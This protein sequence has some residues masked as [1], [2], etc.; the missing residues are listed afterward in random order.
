MWVGGG[1]WSSSKKR[2]T[3]HNYIL[4]PG[5]LSDVEITEGSEIAVKIGGNILQVNNKIIK[6]FTK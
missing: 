1:E 5:S 2:E 6:I 4:Y 3:P